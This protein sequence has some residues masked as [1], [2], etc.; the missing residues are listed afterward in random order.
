M[1][2]FINKDGTIAYIADMAVLSLNASW[3]VGAAKICNAGIASADPIRV[4]GLV[5]R[6]MTI[7]KGTFCFLLFSSVSAT[8]TASAFN[9]VFFVVDAILSIGAVIGEP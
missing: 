8:P 4:C 5:N 3:N 2:K 9:S 6:Q 1:Y 7:G